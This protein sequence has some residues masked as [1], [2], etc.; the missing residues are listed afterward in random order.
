M[1]SAAIKS[2][3]AATT[4]TDPQFN[5]VTMLLHGDGTNGGQNNT[6]LDSS[7]NNFTITRNGNTTQGSFSPYGSNWSNYFDGSGD[8]LTAPSGACISGTGD[9]TAECWIF[10]TTVPGSYNIIGCSDSTNGLTMFGLNANGTIFYGRSGTSVQGTTSNSLNYNTWNHIA[11]SRSSSTLKMFINGVQGFSGTETY[12]YASRTV[13]IGTDGGGSALPY[14]GYI[15]NFRIIQGSAL[16]TSNFTPST[17]PLTAITNTSLLTCQS[18]RFIDN[19]TNNF[20]ITRNG[21]T[22]VQRFSPFAPTAAYSTATIGG[23]G[24]FDGSGDYLAAPSSA[25]LSPSNGA[26]TMECWFYRPASQTGNRGL[27][28]AGTANAG[29]QAV[30]MYINAS[31]IV[32]GYYGSGG[33]DASVAAPV[34]QWNHVALVRTGTG[35]NQTTL[36]LNGVSV[37]TGTFSNTFVSPMP[38]YVG[39]TVYGYLN[40]SEYIN[41]YITDARFVKGT[42]VYTGAFTP[43]TSPLTAVTNTQLLMNYTNGA[44]YDNAMMNDLETVGNAQISTSVVKFGTGSISIPGGGAN[45]FIPSSPNLDMGTGAFTVECWVN[46]TSIAA[47]YP[48]FIS[49]VTGW[50]AGSSGHRFNNSGAANKFTF[51]LNGAGDPFL[52]SGNTFSF[53]VWYHYALTRSG[54]TWRMFINGN[55]EASGT[56]SAAFNQAL[57]GIRLGYAQWDGANGYYNGYIDDL[58]ITKGYA[59]YTANFT[60]P[61]QAFPNN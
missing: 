60:P 14:T 28:M 6:F 61:T 39:T 48:T 25:N 4:P 13:R 24:Y 23:S 32:S 8:S 18:N 36:Y 2:G 16:Y 41:A 37:A 40:N 11:I 54:N 35:T 27:I 51:H 30:G 26:F 20:T 49:S 1:F 34:G 52:T 59:R 43:N 44:I 57:G 12:S 58:R 17:S 55:L 3:A 45:A 22:S 46:S 10:P 29:D 15:S 42:A 56:Y 33:I 50:S 21:D 19:S 53:G 7:T 47:A 38:C 9:F 5:Y 31:N